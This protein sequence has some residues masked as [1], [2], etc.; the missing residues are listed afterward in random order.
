MTMRAIGAYPIDADD[1]TKARALRQCI[2][3]AVSELICDL[4]L[5]AEDVRDHCEAAVDAA[6]DDCDVAP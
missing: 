6:L 1:E 2:E 3:D 4:R 5:D